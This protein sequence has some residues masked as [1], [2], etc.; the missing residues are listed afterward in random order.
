MCK[1]FSCVSRA[2]VAPLLPVGQSVGSR[3]GSR[4]ATRSADWSEPFRSIPRLRVSVG[5]INSNGG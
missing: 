1:Q 2:W 4:R 5:G 3:S